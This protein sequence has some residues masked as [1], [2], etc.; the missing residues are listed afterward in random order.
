M[1]IPRAGG[2]GGGGA[3]I[4]QEVQLASSMLQLSYFFTCSDVRS[5]IVQTHQAQYESAMLETGQLF[6]PMLSASHQAS[7]QVD[8]TSQDAFVQLC[9]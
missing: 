3:C 4:C 5:G 6:L 9:D 7:H 8:A 1:A 2:G